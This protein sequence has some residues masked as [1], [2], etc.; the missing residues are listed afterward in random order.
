MSKSTLKSTKKSCTGET[1]SFCL[2]WIGA[3]FWPFFRI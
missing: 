3:V 1:Y 2:V